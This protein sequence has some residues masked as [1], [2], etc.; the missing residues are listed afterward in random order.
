MPLLSNEF[1]ES[2][3]DVRWQREQRTTLEEEGD[4]TTD[5]GEEFAIGVDSVD[6]VVDSVLLSGG[7]IF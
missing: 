3:F 5:K 2:S 4:P 7:D 1:S 6:A